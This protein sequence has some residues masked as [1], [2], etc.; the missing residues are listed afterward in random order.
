[1]KKYLKYAVTAVVGMLAVVMLAGWGGRAA[2][3]F[4]KDPQRMKR[5]ISFRVDSML[6]DI[7]ANDAQRAQ[8]N[9][10][11]DRLFNEG[12]KMIE[13]Q[14]EAR[15]TLVAEWDSANPNASKI[16]AVVDE[17]IDT[18]RAFAHKL[19]DAAIE[20]HR[21]LTPEQRAALKSEAMQRHQE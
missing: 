9:Q 10:I 19:A 21:V 14:Q 6:D 13:G 12:V 3:G 2:G 4:A 11:K 17:R 20:V 7:K 1:M 5:F 16:H 8:V 18:F 15:K